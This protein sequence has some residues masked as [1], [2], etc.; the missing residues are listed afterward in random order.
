KAFE[1]IN[2]EIMALQ[3]K[4]YEDGLAAAKEITGAKSVTE[5]LEKQT[6]FTKS[7]MDTMVTGANK[8]A[9]LMAAAAKDSTAPIT[10]RVNAS[11]EL[12][13]TA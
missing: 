1:G 6:E 5:Y 10:A 2:A 4:S 9:D 13:K 7:A 3:K 12:F 11:T 8:L